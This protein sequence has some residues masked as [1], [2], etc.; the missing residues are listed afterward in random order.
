LYSFINKMIFSLEH[1]I[2]VT[3]SHQNLLPTQSVIVIHTVLQLQ[4]KNFKRR[5]KGT[6]NL[7]L[8]SKS[9]A[10]VIRNFLVQL[11]KHHL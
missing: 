11:Q 10:L 7:T 1:D 2:K 3:K 9:V 5:I 8:G 6:F 4:V